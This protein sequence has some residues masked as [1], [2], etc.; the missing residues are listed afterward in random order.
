[1]V[2]KIKWCPL[3]DECLHAPTVDHKKCACSICWQQSEFS[4]KLEGDILEYKSGC[5]F[6]TFRGKQY[7]WFT[8]REG[9]EAHLHKLRESL[10]V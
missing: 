2:E 7:G 10:I 3:Q 4:P 8:S 5:F 9:A 1:M 6:V